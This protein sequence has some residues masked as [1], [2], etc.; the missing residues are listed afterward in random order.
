MQKIYREALIWFSD[1]SA[2]SFLSMGA[3]GISIGVA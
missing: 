2:A 1:L 3:F